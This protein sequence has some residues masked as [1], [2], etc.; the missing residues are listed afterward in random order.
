MALW[1]RKCRSFAEE[2]RADREF[3][4]AMTGDERVEALEDLRREASKVTGERLEGFR[5]VVRV[6]QRPPVRQRP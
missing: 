1:V 6:L 2:T 3:W 4:A 5:R